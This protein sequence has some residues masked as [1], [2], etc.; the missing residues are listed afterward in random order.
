LTNNR[1]LQKNVSRLKIFLL[2]RVGP[3]FGSNM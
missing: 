2:L 3:T 1:K